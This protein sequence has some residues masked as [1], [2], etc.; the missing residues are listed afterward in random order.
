MIYLLALLLGMVAGLRAV[1]PLAALAIGGALG[2]SY[3]EGTTFAFLLSPIALW[4]L[5]AFAAL[6]IVNDKLPRTPSRTVPMKFGARIV[7]GACAG[8]SLAVL[9]VGETV[10]Y[11]IFGAIVGAI[12]AFIGTLVGAELRSR[13]ARAFGR[14]LPAALIEDVIAV[15]LA[16]G[17]VY[18][19]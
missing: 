11:L 17:I 12:G 7:A 5:I 6:E 16:F 14:D 13:L 4:A 2:W 8:A 3:L 18:L 19:A 1:T 15:I 10:T 9:P